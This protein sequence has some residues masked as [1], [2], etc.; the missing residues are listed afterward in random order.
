M[1][2]FQNLASPSGWKYR[3]EWHALSNHLDYNV[4]NNTWV[5]PNF[6]PTH[7][8]PDPCMMFANSGSLQIFGRTED[9]WTDTLATKII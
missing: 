7:G 3:W 8:I 6:H 9:I 5:F 4:K 1:G 2:G